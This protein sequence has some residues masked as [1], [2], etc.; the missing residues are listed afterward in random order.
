MEEMEFEYPIVRRFIAYLIDIVIFQMISHILSFPM[1]LLMETV[2]FKV[3][4][5]LGIILGA[6][7]YVLFETSKYRGT[8]GKLWL[9]IELVDTDGNTVS[10]WVS[11]GRLYLPAIPAIIFSFLWAM[12][13]MSFDTKTVI[14]GYILVALFFLCS[15]LT[16]FFN[17]ER[18][19]LWD[20]IFGTCVR[21]KKLSAES[22]S[23]YPIMRRFIAFLIDIAIVFML[24]VAVLN[25]M[26]VRDEF[27]SVLTLIILVGLY[28][29]PLEASK[30]R[31]TL[32]KLWLG[33]ELVNTD[34]NTVFWWVSLGRIVIP[35]ICGVALFIAPILLQDILRDFG[36]RIRYWDPEV[37][38]GMLVV[39]PFCASHL[40]VLFS[41]KRKTLWDMMF[42]TCVIRVRRKQL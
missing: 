9:G 13:L 17:K 29:V 26:D 27:Q 14:F 32:G 3:A 38:S 16:V 2:G 41:K 1:S 22:R 8:L 40:T 20:I 15:Y 21:A 30:Y 12:S 36:I 42:D 18:K 34:S 4:L 39:L 6:L 25:L 23:E 10:W 5:I 33:V 28:F 24:A 19:T 35:I 11:F 7:Y 31:G 37:L